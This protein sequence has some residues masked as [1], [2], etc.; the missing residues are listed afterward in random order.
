MFIRTNQYGRGTVSILTAISMLLVGLATGLAA[1]VAPT[2]KA[3]YVITVIGAAA[4][5]MEFMALA[6]M[7]HAFIRFTASTLING[8]LSV[9]IVFVV[10]VVGILLGTRIGNDDYM[11]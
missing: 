11:S 10:A 9:L 1:G 8:T 5:A 4:I 2:K 7:N 6:G 3:Y